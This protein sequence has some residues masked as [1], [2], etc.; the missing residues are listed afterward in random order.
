MAV[1]AISIAVVAV[2]VVVLTS[3]GQAARP[4]TQL[5]DAYTRLAQQLKG[6]LRPLV[7]ALSAPKKQAPSIQ[8]PQQ[9]GYSCA[10]ASTNGCSLHPCIKYVQSA[11]VAVDA[12]RGGRPDFFDQ[13]PQAPRPSRARSR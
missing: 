13:L 5:P 1:L 6:H 7:G 2:G 3:G 12:A 4:A 10:I 9:Q 8:V 11:G